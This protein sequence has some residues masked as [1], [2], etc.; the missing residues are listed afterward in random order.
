MSGLFC[1]QLAT[2]DA[3][4]QERQARNEA[5]RARADLE[6]QRIAERSPDFVVTI[7]Y[8]LDPEIAGKKV[9]VLAVSIL[10][11]GAPSVATDYK[12]NVSSVL[13]SSGIYDL[14]GLRSQSIDS[15]LQ[16]A[17]EGTRKRYSLLSE[18]D[19]GKR[20]AI[21]IKRGAKAEGYLTLVAPEVSHD[22]EETQINRPVVTL[23]V[24]LK[25]FLGHVHYSQDFEPGGKSGNWQPGK[26]LF[27]YPVY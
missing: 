8:I 3:W 14:T 13:A 16:D 26:E 1:L 21:P 10:N 12:L 22:V 2:F 4:K 5:V 19:L 23:V 20:T 6:Q 17:D 15:I 9:L 27:A 18:A 7:E 11:R 24:S 25:D